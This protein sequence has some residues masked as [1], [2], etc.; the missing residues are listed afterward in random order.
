[1]SGHKPGRIAKYLILLGA[2]LSARRARVPL[3]LCR[4]IGREPRSRTSTGAPTPYSNLTNRELACASI[5]VVSVLSGWRLGTNG[6]DVKQL[7]IRLAGGW[8][9]IA[10]QF[11]MEYLNVQYRGR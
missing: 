10:T 5:G 6:G 9:V 8:V 11:R 1:M 2:S 3:R 7:A 4:N